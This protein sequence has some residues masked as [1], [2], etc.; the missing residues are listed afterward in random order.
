MKTT[1]KATTTATTNA[2]TFDNLLIAYAT[3]PTNAKT[4]QDLATATAFAVL[5]KCI[6]VSANPTLT[7]TRQ[8]IARDLADLDRIEYANANAFETVYTKDG[9]RKTVVKDKDLAS[10][11][12]DLCKSSFGD[13]LDLV[14]DAVVAILDETAKQAERDP[15]KPIDLERPYTMRQLKRKVYIKTADSVNGWET[16]TTTPIQQVYKA[17]RRSIENN[18]SIKTNRN[19]YTYL[20]EIAT[21]PE[22]DTDTVIYRRFGKYADIGGYATDANGKETFYTTDTETVKDL[23]EL[24]AS[25]NLTTKQATVLAL[26][27]QGH[28][29]KAIATYLGVSHQAVDKTLKQ[30]QVKALAI[31][32]T[33]TK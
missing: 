9:D 17:V 12:T 19:G 10:A 27:Q 11:L 2:K 5:K 16:V 7:K 18:A 3:D 15:E 6:T 25:L 1:N 31:G 21:D 23:D 13:G 14:Q 29:N 8:S 33:P 20:D 28:G 32:L 26:R 30:I 4:L 22:T 24:V